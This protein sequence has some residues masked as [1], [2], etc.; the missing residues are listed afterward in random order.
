MTPVDGSDT[1]APPPPPVVEALVAQ[2]RKFLAF[3]ERRVGNRATAEE[4]LQAA[5]VRSVEHA[6]DLRNDAS[7]VAWF[8]RLLR[9]AL[10][11][12]YRRL[13]TERRIFEREMADGTDHADAE[14]RD[15]ICGCL[16]TLLPTL[17]PEYAAILR[18]VDLEERPPADVAG[19][20]GVSAANLRVRLHRAR[21]ALKQQ[22]ERSCGTCAEH[23]CL[24]CAC[25]SAPGP[26]NTRAPS[27]HA[28]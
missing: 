2:H 6:G 19:D 25:G 1:P 5:F 28:Q 15:V 14:L 10:V 8:Y 11:D 21:Q 12:H 9:N 3:L 23:A 13:G 27:Q 22:L 4:I 24:D 26:T 16:H 20:L 17:K 18:E 7:A